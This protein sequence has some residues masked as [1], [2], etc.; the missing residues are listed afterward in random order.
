MLKKKEGKKIIY[1][2]TT[3]TKAFIHGANPKYL[4]SF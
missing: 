4:I 3:R 1:V 2:N